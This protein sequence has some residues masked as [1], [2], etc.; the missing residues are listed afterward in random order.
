MQKV[1]FVYDDIFLMHK[2][3]PW[4]PETKE[5]LISVL[6]ALKNS[7][8]WNKLIHIKPRKATYDDIALTHT[9]NY[10]EK[11]KNFGVGYLDGDT[12]MSKDSLEASL[13]AVGAVMEAVDRCKSNEIHRAFCA[14]RPP[15]HHA[16]SEK[17]MGFCI[18]NNVAVG[19]RYAQKIGYKKVF[20][21]DFD[22]HHGN[23][24]QHI[25]EED[26]TVFYFSTH[27]YPHYPGTGKESEIGIG[28]GKGF[29]YNIT[30]RG[31]SGDKEYMH[32][33]HD[34]LH[35]LVKNFA[36]DIILVSAGYDIRAEDPLSTIKISSEGIR[37]IV[38]GI[39]SSIDKPVVFTLEG[40][41]D[42][43][44]LGESVRITIEEM[45]KDISAPF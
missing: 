37:E 38:H 34:I 16:E 14:V 40:G 44:A 5:R 32:V 26:D 43:D 33:Y 30:M 7:D 35:G 42:L 29:T 6:N 2:T 45:L 19:A 18:F 39:L 9:N 3:P 23:G 21:I 11:I 10:I 22:V 20:I 15:G 17:A 12:Y 41:Y 4:H 27:Q 13:Y 8:L 24:T 28:K 31:G 25:F 36:P 1:G